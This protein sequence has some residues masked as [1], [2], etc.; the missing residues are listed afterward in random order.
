MLKC[1]IFLL[2]VTINC[3]AQSQLY[4]ELNAWAPTISQKYDIIPT[5]YQEWWKEISDCAHL[6]GNLEEV[7][8]WKVEDIFFSGNYFMCPVNYCLGWS[9]KKD[10]YIAANLVLDRR[11]Y[12]TRNAPCFIG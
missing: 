11:T 10:I 2:L 6:K 9:N 4:S 8:W 12:R 7:T 3:N 1:I 5:I